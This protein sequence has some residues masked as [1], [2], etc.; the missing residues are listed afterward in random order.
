MAV[1]LALQVCRI[2]DANIKA[3]EFH[4]DSKNV[5]RMVASKAKG[6]S[7]ADAVR[8]KVNHILKHTEIPWWHHVPTLENPADLVTK[9]LPAEDLIKSDLWRHGAPGLLT[10][11]KSLERLE[12]IDEPLPLPESLI[13]AVQLDDDDYQPLLTDQGKPIRACV[14]RR[15]Q[16]QKEEAARKPKRKRRAKP[17]KPLGP[18]GTAASQESGQEATWP[19]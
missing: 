6:Y 2:L 14:L 18:N 12:P 3:F 16:Q 10:D 9:G 11:P 19:G 1:S 5:L 8:K 17:R 4:T 7:E 13:V 15:M